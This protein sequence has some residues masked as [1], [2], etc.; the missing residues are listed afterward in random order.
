MK[1]LWIPLAALFSL[2]LT[3]CGTS[4]LID[5]QSQPQTLENNQTQVI[6]SPVQSK[7]ASPIPSHAPS[8]TPSPESLYSPLILTGPTDTLLKT[9]TSQDVSQFVNLAKQDLAD[10]L[11]ISIDQISLVK[12]EEITWADLSIGCTSETGK[13]LSKG[14]VTGY[15]VWLEAQG[16][17]YIYHVGLDGQVMYCPAIQPGANNPLLKTPVGTPQTPGK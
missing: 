1:I 9:S 11:K 13:I 3:S 16:E 6:P 14:G 8:Q 17:T 5:R 12:T 10:R 7:T 15:R 2:A 4:Q